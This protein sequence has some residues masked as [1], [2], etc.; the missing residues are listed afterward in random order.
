MG[1]EPPSCLFVIPHYVGASQLHTRH[2]STH[3][4]QQR[5]ASLRQT[6]MALHQHFGTAQCVMQLV[7]RRTDAANEAIRGQVKVII[8]TVAGHDVV[9]AANLPLGSYEHSICD[10]PPTK[11]GYA[12]H[13]VLAEQAS[14]YD[15]LCYLEDDLL[16]HDPL[17]F[18]KL[19]WFNH[20]FG[21]EALLLP[22]RFER[23]Q[24]MLA[25]KAY[26][27]GDLSA[28]TTEAWVRQPA[29]LAVERNLLGTP[30]RFERPR[31]P[32]AGCFFLSREQFNRWSSQPYFL[33]QSDQFIGPLESAATL[34]IL[35]TF[36][37]FKPASVNAGFLE[38]EHQGQ[39]FISQ[40]RRET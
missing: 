21:D 13:R 35:R 18:I 32:H 22:N 27:D 38:I 33:D 28:S 40:L 16:I 15:W 19:T 36:R 23:G 17:W 39:G 1:R 7:K 2:G 30:F 34:G 8:C 11:L 4:R 29:E 24:R 10:T 5:A 3:D 14:N 6:V 31:N 9:A 20:E 12:C 25:T 37:I 26:V